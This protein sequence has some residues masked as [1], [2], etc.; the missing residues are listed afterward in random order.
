MRSTTRVQS[1]RR[2][3]KPGPGRASYLAGFLIL[4]ARVGFRPRNA[5]RAPDALNGDTLSLARLVGQKSTVK[6]VETSIA[7]AWGL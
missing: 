7:V 2:L 5:S 4:G 3:K 6:L 1:F